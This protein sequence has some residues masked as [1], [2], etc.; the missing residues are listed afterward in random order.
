MRQIWDRNYINGCI[1]EAYILFATKMAREVPPPFCWAQ[2]EA[3]RV[4][5]LLRK[6]SASQV[7]QLAVLRPLATSSAWSATTC[8]HWA[9]PPARV[10]GWT[11]LAEETATRPASL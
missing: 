11:R 6:D 7:Y 8:I 1:L 10:R 3:G 5:V 9:P 4:A 2:S